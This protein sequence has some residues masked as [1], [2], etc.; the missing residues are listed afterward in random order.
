MRNSREE[1]TTRSGAKA[2]LTGREEGDKL[3]GRRGA[4]REEIPVS[5][6]GGERITLLADCQGRR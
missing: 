1:V 6:G 5:V 3:A 4:E 2:A